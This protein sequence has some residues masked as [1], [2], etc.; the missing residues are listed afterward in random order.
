MDAAG[1]N[2]VNWERS[3]GLGYLDTASILLFI[4]DPL[5]LPKVN[6]QLRVANKGGVV[7]IAQGDPED[8]YAS[9][10]DRLRAAN[11]RLGSKS[12]AI[13]LTKI[14]VLQTLPGLGSA[15]AAN[16]KSIKAW[17]CANGADGF[18]RRVDRDFKHV[19]YFAV[20]SYGTRDGSNAMHPVRVLD[21]A[22]RVTDPRLSVISQ[23]APVPAREGAA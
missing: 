12:L 16:S 6:E 7:P 2:F 8:S 13:V 19:E 23:Q 22:L 9:V 20:D 1:E 15:N 21:W 14:D 17:L 5:A 18:I 10:V 11:V 4:F 3:Q